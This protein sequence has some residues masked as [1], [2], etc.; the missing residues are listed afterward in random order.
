MEI[1]AVIGDIAE[2]KAGAIVLGLFEETEDLSPEMT[3]ID[4][5]LDGAIT[6]LIKEGE[7]K[8][9]TGE[10]SLIH[11][12]GKLPAARVVAIGLGKRER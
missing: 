1:K 8:G 10:I 2:T 3:K 11:S 12:L 6:N 7:I 5:V 4:K 9:K